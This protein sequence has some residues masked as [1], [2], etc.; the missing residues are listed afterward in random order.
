MHIPRDTRV[1]DC[2][3]ERMR[4]CERARARTRET[5]RI[6]SSARAV[7]VN[8]SSGASAPNDAFQYVL[9]LYNRF[10]RN[11]RAGVRT[12]ARYFASSLCTPFG[13]EKHTTDIERRD[14]RIAR[15]IRNTAQRP[16]ETRLQRLLY[17]LL[18]RPFTSRRKVVVFSLFS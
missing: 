12:S 8:I 11:T 14:N 18:Y 17:R 15:S 9:R 3:R 2:M 5:A 7:G 1:L 10:Y 6:I 4:A 13:P 16:C